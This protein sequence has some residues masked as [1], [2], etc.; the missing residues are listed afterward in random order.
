M[1]YKTNVVFEQYTIVIFGDVNG[2]NNIDSANAGNIIEYENYILNYD[3]TAGS[4]QLV[5][6]DLNGDSNVDSADAGLIV[7]VENFPLNI[8]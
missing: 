5:A 8:D 4:A 3:P 1:K 7:D 2:D 6:A